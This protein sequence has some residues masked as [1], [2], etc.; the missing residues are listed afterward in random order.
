M[1]SL[2]RKNRHVPVSLQASGTADAS[3]GQVARTAGLTDRKNAAHEFYLICRVVWLRLIYW[4][5]QASKA[6]K[7]EVMRITYFSKGG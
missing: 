6:Y 5:R 7:C 1:S 2:G 3:A 4:F